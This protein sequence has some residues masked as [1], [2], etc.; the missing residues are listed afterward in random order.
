MKHYETLLLT[1]Y[2]LFSVT[3]SFAQTLEDDRLALKAISEKMGSWAWDNS[4][5]DRPWQ[6][7]GVPGDNP[8]GWNG[9]TCENGRVTELILATV[10]LSG[11]IP[12]EIGNLTALKSLVLVS[13]GPDLSEISLG[14]VYGPIP[15]EIGNLINLERLELSRNSFSGSIPA[16]IGN[17][18]KLKYLDIGQTFPSVYE[19]PLS[20]PL[21][22]ELGNLVNLEYLNLEKHNLNGNIP[23]VLGNLTKLKHLDLSDNNFSGSF[24]PLLGI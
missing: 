23:T 4:Y 12:P 1:F 7:P 20:D 13:G 2:L 3:G 8:C 24:H 22:N 19:N 21:P 15:N 16:S 9:I 6:F 10:Y 18:V 11:V 5:P 17:L 14:Q